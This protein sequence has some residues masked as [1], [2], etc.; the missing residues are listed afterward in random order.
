MTIVYRT[1][2]VTIRLPSALAIE[3]CFFL[4]LCYQKECKDSKGC[5]AKLWGQ[6]NISQSKKLQ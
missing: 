1:V 5:V 4:K 2:L 6:T 3:L